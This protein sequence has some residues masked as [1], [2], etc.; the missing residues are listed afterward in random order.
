MGP[1]FTGSQLDA[2]VAIK[3]HTYDAFNNPLPDVNVERYCASH[4]PPIFLG[5][6]AVDAFAYYEI[7]TEDPWTEHNGHT[8]HGIATKEG[9]YDDHQYIYDF[10]WAG[11]PYERDFHLTQQ[12]YK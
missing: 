10:R 1:A 2:Y 3:G 5:S 9:F 7:Q 4:D 8:L 11:I 6:T 12:I